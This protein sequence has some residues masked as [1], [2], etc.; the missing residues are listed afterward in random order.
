MIPLL[1]R[2]RKRVR[3]NDQDDV[4]YVYNCFLCISLLPMFKNNTPMRQGQV[5]VQVSCICS[6]AMIAPTT[7]IHYLIL[8]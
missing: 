3:F 2:V 4:Q 6:L 7:K 8:V 1:I 5:C